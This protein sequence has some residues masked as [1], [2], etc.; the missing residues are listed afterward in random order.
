MS[1]KWRLM[2][3]YSVVEYSLLTDLKWLNFWEAV[4]C[5]A[6]VINLERADT[7]NLSKLPWCCSKNVFEKQGRT[8]MCTS[9]SG[10]FKVHITQRASAHL[11]GYNLTSDSE[12]SHTRITAHKQNPRH[13]GRTVNIITGLPIHLKAF[14]SG[15]FELKPSL[16]LE[17][18]I[19]RSAKNENLCF[20]F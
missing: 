2:S 11:E 5:F 10:L 4:I 8:F 15:G 18:R 6:G 9:T 14:K 13:A 1:N 20:F 7:D 3:V 17:A 12:S 16:V 19:A